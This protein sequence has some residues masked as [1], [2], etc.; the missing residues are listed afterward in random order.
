DP[1][2]VHASELRSLP[3]ALQTLSSCHARTMGDMAK[4]ADSMVSIILEGETGTGKEVSARYIHSSSGRQG[5]FVAVNCGA[6][7]AALVES[8]LFGH[9]K[10]AFSG[11]TSDRVGLIQA[12]DG[13]TLFLDE[14][15]ELP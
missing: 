7:P 13:G 1:A 6:L 10:G 8:E 2:D 4:V 12:A 5:A 9:R 3:T 15:A 11:A 14:I